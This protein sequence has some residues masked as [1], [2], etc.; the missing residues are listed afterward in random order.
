MRQNSKTEEKRK[1]ENARGVVLYTNKGILLLGRI[2]CSNGAWFDAEGCYN[3]CNQEKTDV[4]KEHQA[5]KLCYNATI[6]ANYP[7][8]GRDW[9]KERENF[10]D[11][12]LPIIVDQT[13]KNET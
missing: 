7:R 6:L 9:Y 10:K 5:S 13:Y 4:F 8:K 3:Y 2:Q 12:D 1:P 11:I